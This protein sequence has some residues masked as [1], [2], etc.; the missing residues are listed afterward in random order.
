[1]LFLFEYTLYS[2][3]KRIYEREFRLHLQKKHQVI[4]LFVDTKIIHYFQIDQLNNHIQVI[5]A[6]RTVVQ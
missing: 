2:W 3:F 5:G 4:F 6:W 1:M